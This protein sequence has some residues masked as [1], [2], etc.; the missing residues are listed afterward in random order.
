MQEHVLEQIAKGIQAHFGKQCTVS[1]QVAHLGAEETSPKLEQT[2]DGRMIKSSAV[3]LRDETGEALALFEITHDM[4]ELY[5]ATTVLK[6][7]VLPSDEVPPQKGGAADVSLL[8]DDLIEQS[9]ELIGKPVSM[10]Q[11]AD[12]VRAI[13]FLDKKGAFLIKKSGEKVSAFYDISKYTLY[14]YLDAEV[15]G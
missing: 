7:F 9:R 15:E 2:K 4:T 3:M 14:N 5:H 12:K 11:K 10:M 6:K 1:F 13:H 8:L